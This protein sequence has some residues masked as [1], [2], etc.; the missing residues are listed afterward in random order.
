MPHFIFQ[1]GETISVALDAL[2][3]DPAAVSAITAALRPVAPGRLS[4]AP[5]APLAATFAITARGPDAGVPGGWTLTIP[6]SV[7]AG[8]AAGFYAA[9]ARLDVAG[10]VVITEPLSIRIRDAVTAP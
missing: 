3:G 5:D 4:A 1:R 8:L 2:T 10:G 6:D 9:D 7:S